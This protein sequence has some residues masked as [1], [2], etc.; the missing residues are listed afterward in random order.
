MLVAVGV[1]Y[2]AF[3]GFQV[4]TTGDYAVDFAP[5][6]NA[7]LGGHVTHFFGLLPTDGAGG[8]VLG[9][10]LAI[11]RLGALECLCVLAAL[12]IWLARGGGHERRTTLGQAATVGLCVLAPAI[13]SA[14]VI[15]HPEEPLG[16]ALCVGAVLLANRDRPE[17]AAVALACAVINKPWGLFAVP[18]VL[19]AAPSGARMRIVVIA[20]GIVLA[21]LI[22]A[23]ALAPEHFWRQLKDLPAVAHPPDVWWPFAHPWTTPGGTQVHLTPGLIEHHG[24]ELALLAMVPLSAPLARSRRPSLESCLALLALLLLLR[25]LLDPSNHVY[26]QVPF[27]I[28]L[29]AW[30]TRTSDLPALTLLATGLLW[31]VFHTVS[32]IAGLNVQFASYLAV[33]LPFAAIL[34]PSALGRVIRPRVAIVPAL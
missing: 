19:L 27:V 18:P 25:C 33:A 7:L 4:H 30:E 34:A 16:A 29:L 11:F 5:A 6:M 13:L 26:Y 3:E 28:A 1:I 24:R 32:G 23:Y 2:V 31:F 20:G 21:W 22:T 9:S 10:Q 8:S 14:I 17:L 12:G 15:G